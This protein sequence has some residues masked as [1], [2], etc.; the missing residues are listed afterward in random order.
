MLF[1]SYAFIFL[2]MPI[3]VVGYYLI[4]NR[5]HSWAI[6]WLVLASIFFYGYWSLYSLPI[7]SGSVCLN[8]WLGKKLVNREIKNRQFVLVA[9][10][11]LNL[12]CLGYF[13][14]ANFFV[15][16]TNLLRSLMDLKPINTLDVVLPIGISFFT[17]TQIAFLI[18]SYQNKVNE[19]N[20]LK[21]I[22]FVTF[23]PH[24]IAGPVIHHKQM[25][26][27]FS[28]INIFSM[29]AKNFFFGITI[30][31][32]GLAKKILLADPLG[33]YADLMYNGV[34][35]GNHPQIMESWLGSLAYSFQ[36]YFDF[37]GYSDMA[38]GLSLFFGIWLPFNF[39]SP[40]K[41][42]SIIDFWQRWHIS[43]TKYIG[44]YLYTPIT[45]KFMRLAQG[46]PKILEI[47]YSLILPT[48]LIFLI[49]GFWHGANWTY[50]VFGGMHGLYIVINHLWRK[51]FPMPNKK[52]I[53]KKAY[54]EVKKISSWALTFLAVNFSFVMFRSDSISAAFA[55]Y[56]SM[57]GIDGSPIQEFS[58]AFEFLQELLMQVWL[59]AELIGLIV[60]GF[61]IVTLLPSSSELAFNQN[62]KKIRV[63]ANGYIRA[64]FLSALFVMS[65]MHLSKNSSFLY[66]QF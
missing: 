53:E 57:F 41:A 64:I 23:F 63:L 55:I 38:V 47:L 33:R 54:G 21:Y 28:D 20:F 62:S 61:L 29:N 60:I 9:A 15:S 44:E 45:L 51:V 43:L 50:V 25:M 18:D 42:T 56:K 66:F 30:F 37:S 35:F 58:G 65:L 12:A 16:N 34:S 14:Y 1:N 48:C 8:Y 6:F 3:T 10:I 2:F 49:L 5:S 17:F 24:L 40:F 27:Q 26:P 11:I 22:L 19:Q 32:I 36:L 31:V 13:K 4:A 39:N 7:L 46:K 59:K 52:A